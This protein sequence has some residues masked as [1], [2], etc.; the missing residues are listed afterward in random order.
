MEEESQERLGSEGRSVFYPLPSKCFVLV[1]FFFS[2]KK[3]GT[4]LCYPQRLGAVINELDSLKPEFDRRV[5]EL[6]R[7]LSVVGSDFPSYSSDAAVEWPRASY[8]RPGDI[9]KV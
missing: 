5:D 2:L 7:A 8:S 9:N 3:S 1:C 6:N 4:S